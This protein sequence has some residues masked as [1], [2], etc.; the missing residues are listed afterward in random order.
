ML[1]DVQNERGETTMVNK[2]ER[3]AQDVTREE[4]E[5]ALSE[6]SNGK[7]CGPSE[8]SAELLKAPAEFGMYWLHDI[9]NDVRN[10]G[11]IPVSWRKGQMAPTYLVQTRALLR[12]VRTMNVLCH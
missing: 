12:L 3:L 7:A 1:V 10:W 8:V 9:T 4:V 6:M 11:K 2:T 5:I